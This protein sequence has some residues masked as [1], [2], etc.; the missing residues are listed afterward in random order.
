MLNPNSFVKIYFQLLNTISNKH[1]QKCVLRLV[2]A[3]GEGVRERDA[4]GVWG[5]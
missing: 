5:W 2:V 1:H 4:L 3:K